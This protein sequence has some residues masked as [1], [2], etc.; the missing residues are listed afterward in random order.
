VWVHAENIPKPVERR[1]DIV[2]ERGEPAP[3][4]EPGTNG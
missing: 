2:V 1:L 4:P 3:P